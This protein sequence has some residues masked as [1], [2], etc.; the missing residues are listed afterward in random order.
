MHNLNQVKYSV[1]AFL[2]QGCIVSG[3]LVNRHLKGRFEVEFKIRFEDKFQAKYNVKSSC[4]IETESNMLSMPFFYR[5]GECLCGWV[6]GNGSNK[7]SYS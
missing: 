3:G 7:K 5:G 6:T 2:S 1:D 4:T